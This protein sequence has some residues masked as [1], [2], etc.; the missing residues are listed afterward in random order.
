MFL[1]RCKSFSIHIDL[2]AVLIYVNHFEQIKEEMYICEKVMKKLKQSQ[3]QLSDREDLFS[4]SITS[5]VVEK[6]RV[7]DLC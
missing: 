7:L 4:Q 2:F 6:V 5:T 3:G 1:N